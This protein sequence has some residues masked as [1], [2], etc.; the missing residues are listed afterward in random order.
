[1]R[2]ILMLAILATSLPAM[3]VSTGTSVGIG[4][5]G[6]S[7]I[8]GEP[9]WLKDPTDGGK[10]KAVVGSWPQ[11]ASGDEQKAARKK[12]TEELRAT[13]KLPVSV[14]VKEMGSWVDPE[15]TTHIL[16]VAR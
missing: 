8:R 9:A 15:G 6:G 16:L 4:D 1:M 13:F 2:Y 5:K 7:A 3:A 10:S 12:A 11:H 14:K